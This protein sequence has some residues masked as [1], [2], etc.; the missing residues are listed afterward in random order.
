MASCRQNK[1]SSF[2]HLCCSDVLLDVSGTWLANRHFSHDKLCFSVTWSHF[3]ST[4]LFRILQIFYKLIS[5]IWS[6]DGHGT[7]L[8]CLFTWFLVKKSST[9]SMNVMQHSGH[10]ESISN[11]FSIFSVAICGDVF[12]LYHNEY[13]SCNSYKPHCCIFLL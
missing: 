11:T 4:N 2:W 12:Q 8:S 1:M 9:I 6:E 5:L 10:F 3:C 13:A 7:T